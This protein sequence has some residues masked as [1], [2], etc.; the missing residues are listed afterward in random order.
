MAAI[1]CNTHQDYAVKTKPTP[2]CEQCARMWE[3]KNARVVCAREGCGRVFVWYKERVKYCSSQCGH[4]AQIKPQIEPAKAVPLDLDKIR[5]E[6]ELKDLRGKYAESLKTIERQEEVLSWL[7]DMK[8]GVARTMN[9]KPREGSGTS[10]AV[11]VIVASDWH[12]EEIVKPAQTSGLN[13]FNAEICRERV[14]RFWQ[15]SLRLCRLVN[16]DVKVSSVVIAL[17]GDFITNQIHG[18]ENAE[19]NGALP[20]QAVIQAQDK[21][22]AGIELFLNHSKYELIIP[23]KVG[24]H[25]RTTQRVRFGSETGHS[26]E[27]LMY[28]HLAAYFRAEKRVKFVIEDGYHTYLD[29]LGQ[30]IRFHHGHAIQYQGGIGGLFIPAFKAVSQWNKARHADLDVFGHFHQ[31]KDGRSFICNGSLIGYNA[32][33]LSIKADY[34]Q[35]MQTLFLVDKRRGRTCTWPILV[36]APRG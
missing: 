29:V 33:A 34:E 21:I 19:A 23:C 35:P 4:L 9:I 20:V 14:E 17:L 13:A 30:T 7:E 36:E 26:L 15:S 3:R 2:G 12:T 1:V 25:S 27:S 24:N 18:A 5:H 6:A 31:S 28:V 16:Q 11:P 8:Q 10:E 32:F 22:I